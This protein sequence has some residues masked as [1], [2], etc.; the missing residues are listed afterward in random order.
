[1]I[2]ALEHTYLQ[3][4]RHRAEPAPPAWSPS[5]AR[6]R[7]RGRISTRIRMT[8]SVESERYWNRLDGLAERGAAFDTRE[9]FES[10]CVI[11][12]DG[13]IEVVP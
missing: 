5:A 12:A 4:P 2:D 1:M 7:L 9:G 8:D 3:E 6:E 13:W 10:F 11:Y